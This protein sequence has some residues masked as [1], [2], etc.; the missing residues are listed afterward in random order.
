MALTRSW[1]ST[2][3]GVLILLFLAC[4]HTA[5]A[6]FLSP[7]RMGVAWHAQRYRA[8]LGVPGQPPLEINPYAAVANNPLRWIDP[9]GLFTIPVHEEVTRET[10][11]VELPEMLRSLPTMVGQVDLRAGSQLPKNSFMHAMCAPG[12]SPSVGMTML[13]EYIEQELGKCTQEG[14]ASAL[15]VAQDK[16]SPSH[17]RCQMWHG[18]SATSTSQLTRHLLSDLAGRG[19]RDAML[20]SQLILQRF[21]K[22][23][24]CGAK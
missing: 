15:H 4:G 23:C 10:V 8:N 11:R 5:Q 17:Q 13:E 22:Q 2:L 12:M 21:K 18:Q 16:H 1:T 6:R 14:L 3:L 7:D 9:T 19:V 24:P 20:E